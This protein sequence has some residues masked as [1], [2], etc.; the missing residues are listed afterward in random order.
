MVSIRQIAE[1][2]GYSKAS[3]WLALNR[4]PRLPEKTRQKILKVAD[5]LGY[6]PNPAY[7]AMLRQVRAGKPIEYRSTLALFHGFPFPNPEDHFPFHGE[8]VK[9]F[10]ERANEFGYEVEKFWITDPSVRLSRT[11]S[12]LRAR[13]IKGIVCM[14]LPEH[15]EIEMDFSK[16]AFVTVGFT[17]LNPD[18]NRVEVNNLDATI[19]CIRKLFEQG[20]KRIGFVQRKEYEPW[21]EFTLSAPYLWMLAKQTENNFNPEIIAIDESDR[22]RF[23]QWF[24]KGDFDSLIVN[25][26]IIVGWLQDEGI[27]VPR[28]IGIVFPTPVLDYTDFSHVD[29]HPRQVGS[30]AA[31]VLMAQVQ[32]G[33]FGKPKNPKILTTDV[34]WQ[35]GNSLR[36]VGPAREWFDLRI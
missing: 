3:V 32:R 17:I 1:A 24:R 14:P 18:L 7:R 31:D 23:L 22:N 34:T 13:G 36:K 5:E 35:E 27:T 15:R 20:Y 10:T 11:A 6:R 26:E 30:A 12:I 8:L 33:E 29:Q 16:L 9:G 21:R 19:L 2:S 25:D 28:D 4:N